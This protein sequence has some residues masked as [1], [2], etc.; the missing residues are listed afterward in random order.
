[1][2]RED[3]AI[4]D[5]AIKAIL[6]KGE[7]GILSLLTPEGDPY[8]VPLSYVLLGDAIYFHGAMEGLKLDAIRRHPKASF[9][10]VGDTHVLPDKFSTAYESV[11]VTGQMEE[12]FGEEKEMGLRGL[13]EKYSPDYVAEGDVYIKKAGKGTMGMKL[14]IETMTG[15]ARR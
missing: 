9:C 14:I 10:V 7:Y 6:Y 8:G 3:R 11:I 1:M 13:I 4:N 15:K 2:R 12:V 5:E